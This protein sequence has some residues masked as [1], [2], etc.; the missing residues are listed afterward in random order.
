[1]SFLFLREDRYEETLPIKTAPLREMDGEGQKEFFAHLALRHCPGI[2]PVGRKRLLNHYKSAYT[3]IE[4]RKNWAEISISKEIIR[5]FGKESW[6]LKAEKEWKE[7]AKSAASA[8]LWSSP[9]YPARL[10]EIHDPPSYIYCLGDISLLA[11]PMVGVVGSRKASRYGMNMARAIA[12]ELSERGIT[13]ISGMA[14]GIDRHAHLAALD[15]VGKSVGVLGT[16]V[17]VCYPVQNKDIYDRM[18]A[19]GLLLSEFSPA[20]PP[21]GVNFPIRNRLISGLALGVLVVEAAERSGS[22]ITAQYALDQNR[23]VFAAPGKP[24]SP[25]SIGCQNLIR[26]GAH[27]VFC[28][29]DIIRELSFSLKD[30]KY[31]EPDIPPCLEIPGLPEEERSPAA[32]N[33]SA[34]FEE[35]ELVEKCCASDL[36]GKIIQCLGKGPMHIEELS[37]ALNE[38]INEINSKLVFLELLGKIRRLPGARFEAL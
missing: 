32:S 29:D 34:G 27:P 31:K 8:L 20:L 3:A 35:K 12:R 30:F 28:V 9:L 24:L 21:I 11:S 2:G 14:Q 26:Q 25:L 37:E 5:E 1:M 13:V 15:K 36:A 19:E 4:N 33:A 38:N 16:G 22:L 6:R 17:N 10:R 7:A 23:E 18:I